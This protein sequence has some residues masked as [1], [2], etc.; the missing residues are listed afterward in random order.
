MA[1]ISDLARL[2]HAV[3]SGD[4]HQA[5]ALAEAIAHAEEQAGH[6]GA[7][8][9]LKGALS[10]TG[11]KVEEPPARLEVA[12][13]LFAAQPELLTLLTSA[14]RLS[15]VELPKSSRHTLEELLKEHRHRPLLTAHGLQPRSRLFFHGPP[16]CGKTL[17]ACALG[18]ELG[19][20]VYTLRFDTL[21]GSYLGQTSLRL[22]EVFRFAE[23]RP[24][25]LLI[26]EIDAIGRRRGKP[27]DVGELD[28]IVVSLMQQLD[29]ARPAGLIIAASNIPDELDLALLRRFDLTLRFP[30]PTAAQLRAFAR[31]KAAQRGIKLV[32]G[33]LHEL[34]AAKTFAEVEQLIE[35]AHRR[36][37]LSEV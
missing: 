37:I 8:A 33:S 17:T 16:G 3:S 29:L 11:P 4:W 20:Q 14:A 9:T 10:P 19:L 21:V 35:V 18:H 7:A 15:D 25:V 5:R 32:N 12:P 23:L 31:R 13:G 24:C 6:H 30:A 22:R 28:R 27:S 2:F 36:L 26:D 1:R 34:T